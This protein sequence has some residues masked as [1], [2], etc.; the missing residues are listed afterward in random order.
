MK[1]L[2]AFAAILGAIVANAQVSIPFNNCMSTTGGGITSVT[3]D[4]YPVCAGEEFCVTIV[5]T[6][7]APLTDPSTL[8][9]VGTY[10]GVTVYSQS[11]NLCT[12]IT[13][14]LPTTTVTI[15]FCNTIS[16]VVPVGVSR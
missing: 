11:I 15:N 16:P 3:L 6:F 14:P 1:L 10:L 5:G 8:T 12:L 7:S 9:I 2:T 4:P 13:C